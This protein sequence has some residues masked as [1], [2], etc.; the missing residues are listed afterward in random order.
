MALAEEKEAKRF[1]K[2]FSSA[3]FYAHHARGAWL[4]PPPGTAVGLGS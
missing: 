2:T 1:R 4:M 3:W